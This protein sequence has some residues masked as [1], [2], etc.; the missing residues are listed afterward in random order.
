[1]THWGHPSFFSYFP[2]NTCS[3]AVISEL[4]K[5]AFHNPGFDWKCSPANTELETMVC[6]W[7]VKAIGL[8]DKFLFTKSGG[9]SIINTI[10][11]GIWVMVHSAKKRK[12]NDLKMKPNDPN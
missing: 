8:D 1:M 5:T 3:N 7:V 2:S 11:E 4:F 10:S 9:G 12:M 6:D